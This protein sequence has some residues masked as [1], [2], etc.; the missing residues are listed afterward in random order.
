[1]IRFAE[2]SDHPK[3]KALWADAFRDSDA[4]IDQYFTR[5]H[6]DEN[7]L[8]DVRDHTI[9]GMLSMLPVTLRGGDGNN[10][11]AR[12]LYA[13]ATDTHYR[14]RGISTGLLEAAHNHMKALG[15]AAGILVPA[16]PS[17]FDFYAKRGY[18]TA[19]YLDIVSIN[20]SAL[21]PFPT[22]GKVSSCSASEYTRTRNLA[23]QSSSLYARWDEHA[24]SY[25]LQT[26]SH[27][28]GAAMITWE[29]GYGCA[30]WEKTE[31]G[32]LVR[33]LALPEGNPYMAI[34]VLHR[35]LN[36]AHYT[37]RFAQSAAA[38]FDPR[39]FGMIRWLIPEPSLAGAPPYLSL[40][41][42]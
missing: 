2:T 37:V 16:S 8:V 33:E 1:M 36:A 27:T 12:Y 19:F 5:R 35:S 15:E 24:V 21:P 29:N 10:Y 9:A 13:I 18:T 23:F 4:V 26:L 31:H 42:D 41:M 20:A 17:L 39:P 25:S 30:A 28:G 34:A 3:L 32:I 38:G 6:T 40:A 11:P 7:M 22:R 14:G